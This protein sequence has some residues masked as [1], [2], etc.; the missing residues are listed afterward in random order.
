MLKKLPG[1][2][3]FVVC[4]ALASAVLQPGGVRAAETGFSVGLGAEF[5]SGTYRTGTRTESV[6]VPLTIAVY[7]SE[8]L[9]FSVEIPYVYQSSGTVTSG[10]FGQV[11]SGGT[12]TMAGASASAAA[13]RG[14]QGGASPTS[15]VPES[16]ANKSQS[17]LGDIIAKA[18]YIVVTEGELMPEIRPTVFVKFP[19]G[20]RDKALGTGEYDAGASIEAT[21]WFGDWVVWGE[22]GYVY[23]GK[24]ELLALKDYAVYNGAIGYQL[25]DRLRPMVIIKG[26][27][28]PAEGATS[29][30]EARARLKWQLTDSVGLDGYLG[31][32][33]TDSSPDYSA[34]LSAYYDY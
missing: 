31:K 16:S 28:A 10:V 30:L 24:S 22:G 29:L 19:T 13:M 18:G 5:A 15:A 6:Y 34:G 11:G 23:Q 17:G 1:V 12:M 21:K 14:P 26:A 27:T 33:I 3:K 8:R 25:T 4:A 9:D 20:D 2:G 7:P 32:G